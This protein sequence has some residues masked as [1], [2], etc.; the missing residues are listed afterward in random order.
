[1]KAITKMMKM[2]LMKNL[3]LRTSLKNLNQNF[4]KKKVM[5]KKLKKASTVRKK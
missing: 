4:Q 2:R 5:R 3:T 1:M